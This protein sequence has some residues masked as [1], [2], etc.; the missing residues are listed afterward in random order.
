M[1]FKRSDCTECVIAVSSKH[2]WCNLG[3]GHYLSAVGAGSIWGGLEKK[4]QGAGGWPKKTHLCWYVYIFW[5][6][7]RGRITENIWNSKILRYFF[8]YWL[9]LPLPI[10]NLFQSTDQ[11]FSRFFLMRQYFV[12]IVGR[13]WGGGISQIRYNPLLP[14]PPLFVK[15]SNS[16]PMNDIARFTEIICVWSVLLKSRFF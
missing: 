1:M 16:C 2:L 8:P 15:F 5:W 3:T 12:C 11:T 7:C 14:I 4:C 10:N 9:C 13:R 6:K